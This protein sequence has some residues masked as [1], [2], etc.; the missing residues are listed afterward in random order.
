M[1]D[2]VIYF[3]FYILGLTVASF[4]AIQVLI[5]CFFGIPLTMRL[6][7]KGLLVEGNKIISGHL[8]SAALLSSIFTMIYLGIMKFF[9]VGLLVFNIGCLFVL[10]FGL[11]RIGPNEANLSDYWINNKKHFKASQKSS[12]SLSKSSTKVESRFVEY[13]GEIYRIDS[14]SND[15]KVFK[16]SNGV[17]TPIPPYFIMNLDMYG[18]PSS[19]PLQNITRK[20]LAE[21]AIEAVAKI[22]ASG[23]PLPD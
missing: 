6:N 5:I 1:F 16:F 23:L 11:E 22:K 13:K 10:F 3:L 12:C 9:P 8:V 20:S 2:W 18:L 4:T 15:L 21:K 7:K 17:F 14:P 19:D